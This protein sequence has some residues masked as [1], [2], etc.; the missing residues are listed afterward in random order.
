MVC[1][2]R[3]LEMKLNR[4][5]FVVYSQLFE[6]YPI[7]LSFAHK[8]KKQRIQNLGMVLTKKWYFGMILDQPHS[9][10]ERVFGDKI[11]P[12][13]QKTAKG[14]HRHHRSG[15]F[16]PFL[17]RFEVIPLKINGNGY[18]QFFSG[19]FILWLSFMQTPP[20][21]MNYF[22]HKTDNEINEPE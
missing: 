21:K 3:T 8:T 10:N 15:F 22:V 1:S 20:M 7:Q 5:V 6:V 4:I 14:P 16:S 17:Q 11:S 19:Q 13:Y 18:Y 2:N 9:G 12:L